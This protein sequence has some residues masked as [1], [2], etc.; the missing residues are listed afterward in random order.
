M[1]NEGFRKNGR[2]M[3]TALHYEQQLAD[4]GFV[5]IKVV[6]ERWPMNKWPRDRKYKQ[7]GMWNLENML[8][9]LAAVSLAIFTRPVEE[10]GLGWS[11]VELEVLL[12][13]VRN[14]FKNTG[15]H[16]YFPM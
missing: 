9:G 6:K 3:D 4:A 10:N 5:N 16:A 1:C 7:L 11:Q 13:T 15:I 2:P 14:D 8:S 12:A